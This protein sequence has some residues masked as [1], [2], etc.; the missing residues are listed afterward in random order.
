MSKRDN[1]QLLKRLRKQLESW[2]KEGYDVNDLKSKWHSE[3]HYPSH[4]RNRRII[5]STLICLILIIAVSVSLGIYYSNHS[6]SKSSVNLAPTPTQTSMTISTSPTP[7]I[8]PAPTSTPTPTATQSSYCAPGCYWSLIGDGDCDNACYNAAC[9]WDGGDCSAPTAAPTQSGDCASGCPSYCIA[10]TYCDWECN[11]AACNYDG[12]DCTQYCAAGCRVSWIGDGM[13]DSACYSSACNWD[14]GDCTTTTTPT[15][16]PI[17]TATPTSQH[18]EYDMLAGAYWGSWVYWTKYLTVGQ[19]VTGTVTM[20]GTNYGYDWDYTW[21]CEILN[22]QDNV[23]S[24]CCREWN[25]G[26]SCNINFAAT[27]NGNYKVK[28]SNGSYWTKRVTIDIS[29]TGW[30]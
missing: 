9:N 29:P 5:T 25:D 21:C 1:S 16:T 14:G 23:V 13:C 2:E 15:W 3:L 28:I 4:L 19:Q 26:T 22:P 10:D 17:P 27:Q 12:G 18:I 20:T 6:K 8:T 7:A 24:T 30:Y 11:N